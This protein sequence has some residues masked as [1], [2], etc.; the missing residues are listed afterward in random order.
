MPYELFYMV[1]SK[2]TY[3]VMTE[4][5]LNSGFFKCLFMK[6]VSVSGPT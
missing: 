5:K 6:E 3:K 1:Q 2:C 4:I